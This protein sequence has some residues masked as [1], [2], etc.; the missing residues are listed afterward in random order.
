M[1]A[2][3]AN[4][5]G[6]AGRILALCVA[7]SI[8]LLARPSSGQEAAARTGSVARFQPSVPGDAMFGVPSPVV[9]GHLVPR[10]AVIADYAYLPL[11]IEDGDT[12]QAIVADQLFLHA[13][14]SFA[15]FD[16]VLLSADMPF[17]LFQTGDSPTVGG[18]AFTSPDEAQLGDLRLGARLRLYGDFWDP[19][20]IGV[21]GYIF[22]PTGP[23]DSYSG[24]GSVR[25]EPHL[26]VGGRSDHFVYSAS[27]GTTLR[28]S[29]RPHTFDARAGAALVLGEAFFQIGPE[30]TVTAPLSEDVIADTAETRITAASPVGAELLLGAKVRVLKSIVIGAGA[31]P[32]LSQAWGT[33]VFFAAGSVAYEPLPPR[34]A[35]DADTDGDKILD[36]VDAC[37]T[38]AGLPNDDPKKHGCPDTDRDGIV[39]AADVA[40]GC[41]LPACG[42]R[43]L[44]PW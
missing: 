30:L 14:V 15:L 32:G 43:I 19:F 37:P 6:T 35:D 27:L 5:G 2:K 41:R 24:D 13:A 3:L 20:Q 11:S 18:V 33:P 23:S 16:R 34:K 25:G 39:D 44:S 22:T 12:R 26:L 7:C 17:A 40:S 36:A 38:V 8:G 42:G 21:G 29:S 28:A 9:G 10:A 4:R 31:G 1:P